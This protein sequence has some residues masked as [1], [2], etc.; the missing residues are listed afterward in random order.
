M[1]ATAVDA[2]RVGSPRTG[3][4]QRA[5]CDTFGRQQVWCLSSPALF[6]TG[7]EATLVEE[8]ERSKQSRNVGEEFIHTS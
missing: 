5:R 3:F 4:V 1:C 7:P 8:M 2:N 6:P